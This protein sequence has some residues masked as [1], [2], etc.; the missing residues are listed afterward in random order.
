MQTVQECVT[1]SDIV[2]DL[3]LCR[4]RTKRIVCDVIAPESK[5]RLREILQSNKFSIIVDEST[6]ITV[7]ESLCVIVRYFDQDLK[8]FEEVCWDLIKV[9]KHEDSCCD[10]EQTTDRIISSFEDEIIL[11]YIKTK[12]SATS[13]ISSN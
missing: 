2:K 4:W 9:Y 3:K 7:N 12:S 13:N 10:A 8:R 6:D 1:D 5:A 11:Y